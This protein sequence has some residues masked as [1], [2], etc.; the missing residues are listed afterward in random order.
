MVLVNAR[1]CD[2]VIKNTPFHPHKSPGLDDKLYS[3]PMTRG[4]SLY[5]A[6]TVHGLVCNFAEPAAQ[7][8]RMI[9]DGRRLGHT[10]EITGD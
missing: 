6:T 2:T 10:K 3:N 4:R 5:V 9:Q 8:V 1:C 7:V